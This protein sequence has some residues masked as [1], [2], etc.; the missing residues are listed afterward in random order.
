MDR[1]E[2]CHIT[3]SNGRGGGVPMETWLK[4]ERECMGC[5]GE[6]PKLPERVS[7]NQGPYE[8]GSTPC[9]EK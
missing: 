9:L 1:G 7:V 2:G 8:T 5:S 3:N 6:K 4:R